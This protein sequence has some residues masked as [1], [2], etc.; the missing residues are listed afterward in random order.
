LLRISEKAEAE[1]LRTELQALL[2]S[3]AYQAEMQKIIREPVEKMVREALGAVQFQD[4]L[5]RKIIDE[6]QPTILSA[7]T[8]AVAGALEKVRVGVDEKMQQE[9]RTNAQN[10][11]R[12]A[13]ADAQQAAFD[14]IETLTNETGKKVKDKVDKAIR[15]GASESLKIFDKEWARPI[16]KIVQDTIA[17]QAIH[18]LDK[19]AVENA[20]TDGRERRDS[21]PANNSE[22]DVTGPFVRNVTIGIA[23][24]FALAL[25]VWWTLRAPQQTDRYDPSTTASSEG[26]SYVENTETTETVSEG[27]IPLY[28]DYSAVLSKIAADHKLSTA[29]GEQLR[30]AKKAIAGIGTTIPLDVASLQRALN[31]CAVL[32]SSPSEASVIVAAVQAG[33]DEESRSGKCQDLKSIGVDGIASAG[34]HTEEALKAYVKC[35]GPPGVPSKAQTLADYAAIGIYFT[36]LRTH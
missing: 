10:A 27:R 32:K 19:A 13:Y 5:K 26:Q 20:V 21:R 12:T 28:E 35:T 24:A 9:M 31:E 15:E 30:C 18:A 23:A 33:L 16:A 11:L 3:S 2:A 29:T 14:K 34:G 22:I 25:L 4:Q 7:A 1:A 8:Q 6:L 17:A 36:Y